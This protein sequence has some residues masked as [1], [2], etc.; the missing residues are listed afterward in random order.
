M[1]KPLISII[2][3]SY[4]SEAT[5]KDTI[6][7]VLN[8]TYKNFEYIIIDGA[9]SDDTVRIIKSYKKKFQN[10]GISFTFI[11]EPDKGIYN[12]FNKGMN[13]AKGSW[14]CFIGSDDMFTINAIETYSENL[15]ENLDLV[16][17]NVEILGQRVMD[18]FWK[19]SKFRRK[20]TIPHVGAMHNKEF[21]KKYGLFN[22]SYKIA[23]DYELLLRANNNLKCKKVDKI[24]IK[25]V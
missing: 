4:N 2:T 23:A 5:I 17:S 7:S 1:R 14:V 12:A 3:A 19:W 22:T 11:S 24:L 13:L 9:S 10:T 6:E 20:M 25:M 16:Y 18:G 21:F 8:Q 15:I